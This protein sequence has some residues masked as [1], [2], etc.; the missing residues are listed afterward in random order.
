MM[1]DNTDDKI[2]RDLDVY[3]NCNPVGTGCAQEENNATRTDFFSL[4]NNS[5]SSGNKY[6]PFVANWTINNET[7]I[8]YGDT[9]WIF[10]NSADASNF[11]TIN[12]SAV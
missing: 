5:A 10:V 3:I 8:T 11:T 4:Y 6:I 2:F 9:T 12:W 7:P 1:R